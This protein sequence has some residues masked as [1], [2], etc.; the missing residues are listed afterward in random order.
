LKGPYLT[1]RFDLIR[2]VKALLTCPIS[3]KT[4][5]K[6]IAQPLPVNCT[7]PNIKTLRVYLKLRGAFYFALVFF[8]N[9][10]KVREL[11]RTKKS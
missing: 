2:P 4:T 1:H 7:W 10:G 3:Q 8:G 11:C 9:T 5:R 6:A